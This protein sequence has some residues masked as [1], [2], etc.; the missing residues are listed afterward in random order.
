MISHHKSS[1]TKVKPLAQALDTTGYKVSFY[2]TFNLCNYV[3]SI[4]IWFDVDSE[5]CSFDLGK[6]KT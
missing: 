2:C 5:D 6:R 4:N 1:T 3:D